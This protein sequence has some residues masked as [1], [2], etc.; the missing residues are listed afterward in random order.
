MHHTKQVQTLQSLLNTH[1]CLFYYMCW[2]KSCKT[3]VAIRKTFS[4][5]TVLRQLCAL[6]TKHLRPT[7]NLL[8]TK[9]DIYET[10]YDTL[11]N[12][13]NKEPQK[14]IG[15]KLLSACNCL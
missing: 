3:V 15:D 13:Y 10:S 11:T 6:L 4:L 12:I 1:V 2:K 14:V 5:T 9:C 7:G 8:V